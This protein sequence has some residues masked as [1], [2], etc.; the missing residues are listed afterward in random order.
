MLETIREYAAGRLEESGAV[1]EL[2]RRCARFFVALAEVAQPHLT[3]PTQA[4]WLERL[5]AEHEN[6]RRA[7]QWLGERGEAELQLRLVAALYRFWHLRGFL[8]EGR[9]WLRD[10]LRRRDRIP[11]IARGNALLGAG[12][13]AHW[14]HDRAEVKACANEAVEL[15]RDLGDRRGLAAALRLAGMALEDEGCLEGARRLREESLEISRD[16]G[17][18]RDIAVALGG[19]ASVARTEG[20][21]ERAQRLWKDSLP[22]FRQSGDRYGLAISLFG[23]AFAA[24]D[25]QRGDEAERYLAEALSLSQELEYE[26]GIA[27]YLLGA[28]ALAVARGESHR[29]VQLLGRMDVLCDEIAFSMNPTEQELRERTLIPAR[30]SLGESVVETALAEGGVRSIASMLGARGVN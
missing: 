15:F 10:A 25:E 7:L 13:L 3:G 28:A 22:L 1:D 30:A 4:G 21:Y 12:F 6:F 24:V 23:L 18:E 20:D 11:T 5:H 9:G 27:Y 8:G 2:N 17:D 16:L 14:Q 19:L 26:E 29:G